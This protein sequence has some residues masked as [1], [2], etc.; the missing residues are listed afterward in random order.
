MELAKNPTLVSSIVSVENL[1]NTIYPVEGYLFPDTYNLQAGMT[2]EQIMQMMIQRFLQV[3]DEELLEKT[4]R[5][6]L[7]PHQVSTIA[8]LVEKEAVVDEERPIIA[9]VY[10]NRIKIGMRLDLT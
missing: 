10:L 6:G 7:T 3:F 1:T 5:T 8:A 9:A 4:A 2:E